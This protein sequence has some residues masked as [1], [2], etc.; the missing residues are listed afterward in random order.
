MT[1]YDVLEETVKTNNN[2]SETNQTVK[3][4]SKSQTKQTTPQTLPTQNSIPSK[5]FLQN[6]GEIKVFS[7]KN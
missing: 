4:P 5:N 3:W 1:D 7:E 2:S 6:E